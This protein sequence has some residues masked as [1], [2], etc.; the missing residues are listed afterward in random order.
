[1][2]K[3]SKSSKSSKSPRTSAKSA[4]QVGGRVAA[5]KVARKAAPVT[6]L[7]PQSRKAATPKL[8]S[9]GNPQIAKG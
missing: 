7:K 3:L 1:M 6:P 4:K 9:G 2:A 8:L 5:K